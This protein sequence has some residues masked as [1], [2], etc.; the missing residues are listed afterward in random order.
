MA[1]LGVAKQGTAWDM[2]GGRQP[3]GFEAPASTHGAVW[4]GCAWQGRARLGMARAIP[5]WLADT[6]VRVPGTHARRGWARRGRAW[7]GSARLGGARVVGGWM[8]CTQVRALCT[9]NKG[10]SSRGAMMTDNS[11]EQRLRRMADRQGFRLSRNR[12][13]DRRAVD[14]GKYDLLRGDQVVH[15]QIDL[16]R[17]ESILLATPQR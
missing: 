9:H 2:A 17:V 8:A 13:R 15:R 3:L 7:R 16:D 12:R 1:W 14:Y 5:G 10:K 4:L 11:F 6:G